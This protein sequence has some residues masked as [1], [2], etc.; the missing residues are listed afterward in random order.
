[1][2]R[3]LILAGIVISVLSCKKEEVDQ[4]A[5]DDQIIRDYLKTQPD[6]I[7]E[8][9]IRDP[10][11]LYYVILK[12]G[13]GTHP[14]PYSYVHVFYK[15]WLMETGELFEDRSD[16]VTSFNLSG[17]IK[18]WQIGVP[19]LDKQGK[20]LFYIPSGLAYGTSGSGSKIPPNSVLIFEIY[21][22]D[23]E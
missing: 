3:Y 22:A 2:I 18:G 14:T 19:K 20:G 6:S 13:T 23:F 15:G 7:Q 21:L 10:S 12:E 11:G 8:N 5:I 17:V 1:M 4:A 16:H 9:V